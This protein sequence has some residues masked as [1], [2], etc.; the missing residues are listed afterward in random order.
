[1]G[2]FVRFVALYIVAGTA[3][4]L[5]QTTPA[6]APC[7]VSYSRL[8]MPYRH[9]GGASTPMVELSF[10]N[11]T[12]KK[13]DRAKFGLIVIDSDGSQTPYKGTL[14]FSAGADPGK[15]AKAEWA[16]DMERIDIQRMGET[17]FLKSVQFGDG[18][19]WQDDGNQR[20]KQ[21]IYYGPK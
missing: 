16:L 21:E 12:K 20:C 9:A 19:A 5:A 3:A 11:E 13:I 17:V 4:G 1:L 18:T 2:R 7:P 10:T 14:T 6:P 15:Q 8:E